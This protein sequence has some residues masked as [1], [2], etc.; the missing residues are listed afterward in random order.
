MAKKKSIES[1]LVLNEEQCKLLEEWQSITTW[2]A[3]ARAREMELRKMFAA[4]FVP[5]PVE[6]TTNV[7]TAQFLVKLNHK[8]SRSLD[9]AVLPAVLEKL[10]PQWENALIERK[11][12]LVLSAYRDLPDDLKKTFDQA[13]TIKEG[14][15]ELT[16]VPI[17]TE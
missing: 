2:M 9:E 13:L 1:D 5:N 6:G 17:P 4:M 15:P 8:L 11:P 10:G 14:A 16:V 7:K 3:T 12:T